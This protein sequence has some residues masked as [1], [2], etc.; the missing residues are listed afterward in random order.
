MSGQGYAV[1]ALDTLPAAGEREGAAWKP[2][3]RLFDV[4][5]FGVNAWIA[6]DE[7]DEVVEE[8]TEVEDNVQGHEELY[9]VTRGYATFIVGDEELEAPAGT[10]VFVKDPALTR[11][12]IARVRGTTVVAVGQKPGSFETSEWEQRRFP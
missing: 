9:V 7:G 5:A 12:A 11:R 3:H 6:R 8:H 10:V 4:T 1:G 2:L